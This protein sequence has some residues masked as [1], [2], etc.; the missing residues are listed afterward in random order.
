MGNS[1]I[2][3]DYLGRGTFANRP[4]T[5]GPIPAG[6]TAFYLATD[7]VVLYMWSGTAWVT[8]VGTPPASAAFGLIPPPFNPLPLELTPDL[9][10][11]I[12]ATGLY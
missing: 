8:V 3:T 11:A 9:N 12:M 2:I 7:I 6:A 10:L 5:P 1:T 4:T